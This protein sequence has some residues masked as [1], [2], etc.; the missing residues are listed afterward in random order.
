M[1]VSK[2]KYANVRL[3]I[4]IPARDMMHTATSFCLFNLAQVLNKLGIDSKLFI[5]PG[6]LIANQRHELV[7]SAE[8]WQATHVMFIDSDI[9]FEPIHVLRLL[10]FDELIVGA[11]YSKRVEPL[12]VTAWTEIDN[13][14]SWVD[15]IEQTQSHI[16]IQAMGLGF[17]LIKMSVF[18]EL[19]LPWFQL[20]FYNG[21]YTGEDIEFFRKCNDNNIDIWLDIAT[22]CELGHIGVKN[23]KVDDDIVVDLET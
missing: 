4:C 23:Y 2:K 21:Q 5:S 7:K 20:G 10:D 12:I 15:P 16:K 13:W 9:T 11:A 6:T 19:T 17:C 1:S 18:D 3:A 14:D 8:E 22:T